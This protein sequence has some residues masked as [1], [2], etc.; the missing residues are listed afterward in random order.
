MQRF[1]L[2]SL[3]FSLQLAFAQDCKTPKGKVKSICKSAERLIK[4]GK[5]FQAQKSLQKIKD[6][7]EIAEVNR[8]KAIAYWY[9]KRNLDA[10]EYALNCISICPDKYAVIYYLLGE[11]NFK[12]KMYVDAERYLQKAI[13]IGL[14]ESA[15][16]KAE[17]MYQQAKAIGDII[18]NPVPFNPQVVKGI[19][20]TADEYLP[21]L[22]PDQDLVFYTRRGEKNEVGSLTK[23]VTEEFIFS[24]EE[25]AEFSRG[26]PMPFPF[27]RNSNEG[28]A[29]I[30]ID[31]KTLY[32]TA[33]QNTVG[34]YNNCDLF[35]TYKKGDDWSEIMAFNKKINRK[36][37]WESQPSVSADG[38]SLIFASD[39]KGG[40]GAADLYIIS[41][42]EKG[43]WGNPESLGENINTIK[44]EKSPFLH[45]D[46]ETLFFASD[47]SPSVGG[48]DIF[49]S[50][51]DS[52]G[53][54][55]KP[56]NIGFPINTVSDE[57][58][59]F[60]STDGKKAYFASNQLAGVG[61]WDLYAF[62]LYDTAKPKKV[63][64]LKG[65]LKDENGQ[66]IDN[67]TIEL[68]NIKSK[69]KHLVQVQNGAYTAAYTLDEGDDILL[70][71]N[72]EGFAFNATYLSLEDNVFDSPSELDLSIQQLK[73]GKAFRLDNI[74]FATNSYVLNSVSK[75]ILTAFA[76]YLILN[77]NLKV[78]IHGHTDNVGSASDNLILSENRA[79]AV[80]RYLLENGLTNSKLEYKGFGEQQPV[81]SNE[82]KQ[83]RAKNRRTEFMILAQ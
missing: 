45:T 76:D 15:N 74:Y 4:K 68:K 42:N 10:E 54:W 30:T 7:N 55:Q 46:N 53:N 78:A 73:D 51:K 43:Q 80:F 81:S 6:A 17:A 34:G 47:Q 25:S 59:L 23:S 62:D 28:G 61:G 27:N 58:G 29:S 77:K 21:I 32:F 37:S 67:A 26:L 44:N 57:L 24:Q 65:E 1:L 5:Y 18:Q 83:G 2:F 38:N 49:F 63:L 50:R 72:K 69:E 75:E 33:C 8:L 40:F 19:S 70:T 79:N 35:Y 22:S 3:L 82:S 11:I 41:K 66:L 14:T 48:Y 52:L 56:Q 36:D 12:R 39:R 20:T 71:V 13:A 64:F 31:N 16:K 9:L 60:V